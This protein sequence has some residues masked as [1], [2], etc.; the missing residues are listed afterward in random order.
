MAGRELR[1]VFVSVLALSASR[2]PKSTPS[3]LPLPLCA[4]VL[5]PVYQPTWPHPR[6]VLGEACRMR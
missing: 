2:P 6:A 5:L 4:C 1:R 3:P